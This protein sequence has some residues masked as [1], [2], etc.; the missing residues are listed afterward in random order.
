MWVFRELSRLVP[1]EE[2]KMR[3]KDAKERKNAEKY[4]S[5]PFRGLY[6][7]SFSFSGYRAG[8]LEELPSDCY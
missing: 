3:I 4:A 8:I 6:F 1:H 2:K 5:V 7:F